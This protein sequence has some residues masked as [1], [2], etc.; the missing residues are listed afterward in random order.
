MEKSFEKVMKLLRQV[1]ALGRS[2]RQATECRILF[3]CP[4]F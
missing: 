1:G 3:G 2:F 4:E